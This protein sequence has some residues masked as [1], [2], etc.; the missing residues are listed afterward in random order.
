MAKKNS[1]GSS[2]DITELTDNVNSY[3]KYRDQLQ[4]LG[5]SMIGWDF[6][7]V[8]ENER[9]Y[10]NQRH[11]EYYEYFRGVTVF[12]KD[13][14][15]GEYLCMPVIVRGPFDLDD[16]PMRRTA[17][18]PKSQYR[19]ELTNENS[20]LIY[21]NYLRKPCYNMMHHYAK[22]L[23]DIE[24]AIDVN[25]KAQKTPVLIV[26]NENERLT[27]KQVYEQYEGNYPVIFG[28]KDLNSKGVK[29]LTTGAPFVAEEMYR[30]KTMIWNEA[31]TYLG[32]SNISFQK[33]ER[34]ITD[35]VMRSMGGTVANRYARLE[36]RLDA[37]K[38][39]KDM[40]GIE[41]NTYFRDDID[42]KVKKDMVE[43]EDKQYE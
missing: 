14:S 38:K 26:C 34:L 18:N 21:N 39:I 9:R 20:V 32:I 2:R 8:P 27:M 15:L 35:E 23:A 40:F 3:I 5:M 16:M 31:L 12:Y 4:E 19:Y 41:I 29:S 7:D 11:V 24:Q 30:I 6:S 36:T 13:E 37:C 17:Y 43:L 42:I 10:L 22:R 1:W 25:C 33:R 28:E